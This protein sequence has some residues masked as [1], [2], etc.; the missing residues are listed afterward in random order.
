MRILFDLSY[1]T[2]LDVK[3][4]SNDTSS[5]QDKGRGFDQSNIFPYTVL[6]SVDILATTLTRDLI[7]ILDLPPCDLSILGR[8]DE[9]LFSRC[10]LKQC[11]S[12]IRVVEMGHPTIYAC[13]R[14]S[15]SMFLGIEIRGD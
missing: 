5:W 8:V 15:V 1:K 2:C 6:D 11:L 7:S 14:L 13:S 12:N 3:L 10:K 4:E 9:L